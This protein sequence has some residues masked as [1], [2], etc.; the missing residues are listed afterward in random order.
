MANDNT[1]IDFQDWEPEN[2][3]RIAYNTGIVGMRY[4]QSAANAAFRWGKMP[5]FRFC[6][7]PDNPY[8]AN[9]V[10]VIADSKHIGY[11]SEEVAEKV[12]QKQYPLD[13][14]VF[15]LRTLRRTEGDVSGLYGHLWLLPEPV[16]QPKP[17]KEPEP[18]ADTFLLSD[19]LSTIPTAVKLPAIKPQTGAVIAL[20]A[21]ILLP[22]IG[23]VALG[24]AG[25]VIGLLVG[26]AIIIAAALVVLAEDKKQ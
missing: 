6:A 18:Q 11:L 5:D 21:A 7:E 10:A 22:I 4:R 24:F 16:S 19:E 23:G 15:Q 14:L 1:Y 12:A 25:I 20:I 26:I 3:K 9:A 17:E 2:G 13:Q 8:D